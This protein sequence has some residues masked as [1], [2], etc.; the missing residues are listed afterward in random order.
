VIIK[1][2]V[3]TAAGWGTRFLPVTKSQPKEMLPLLDKPIIQYSVEEVIACGIELVVIVTA[4]G[5]RAIEDYF[6]RNYELEQVLARK[7]ETKLLESVRRSSNMVDIG[8]IRQK[9]QS[10]LGHAVLTAK[11]MIGNGPFALLLPD[12]LFEKREEVL[13][14]MIQI[15]EKYGGAVVAVKQVTEEEISRYGI[16]KG[17]HVGECI[18]QVTDL[19]EKPRPED[20]PSNLAIMGRYVLVPEIFKVLENT[21]PGRNGEIQLTD[22]LRT[23]LQNQPIYGY[24]FEGERYDAGTP[25]GLLETTIALGLKEPTIGPKLRDYLD[26]LLKDAYGNHSPSTFQPHVI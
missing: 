21:K 17:K 6:D 25:L 23:L 5:K 26:V 11:N 24:E 2:A 22:A 4:F 8:Y 15:Y 12:D 10:G 14:N 19:V 7:G 16:I 18:Y 1:K 3:I 9:E 13:G 20:A